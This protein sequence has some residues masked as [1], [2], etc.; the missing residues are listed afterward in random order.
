MRIGLKFAVEYMVAS[1]HISPAKKQVPGVTSELTVVI[2][3]AGLGRRMK[4]KDPKC[5]SIVEHGKT[6]I[7]RQLDMIWNI[8]PKSEIFVV[9]GYDADN[10]RN[11][12]KGYPIR[13]IYNPL[14]EQTNV[15]FS[16][17]LALQASLS[18]KCLIIYGDLIFN[19]DSISSITSNGSRILIDANNHINAD[20][21]GLIIDE[22]KNISNFSF[23]LPEKWAQIA[24]LEDHELELFKS[25]CYNEGSRKWFGYEVLNQIINQHG[26]LKSHKILTSIVF[27]IDTIQDLNKA[28]VVINE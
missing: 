16:L 27:D 17:G 5:L 10:I 15:T 1:R 13:F 2:P 28:K 19:N 12:L 25:F 24:Y 4:Y 18:K 21:V 23:G 11:K 9:I 26:V 6:L 22:N 20:E 8:Y 7:E 3:A 14:F